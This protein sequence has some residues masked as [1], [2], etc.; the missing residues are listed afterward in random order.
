MPRDLLDSVQN[1]PS[2]YELMGTNVRGLFMTVDTRDEM[3]VKHVVD[4]VDRCTIIGAPANTWL[5]PAAP[6]AKAPAV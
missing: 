2:V 5:T 1:N 3:H 4:K 6:S